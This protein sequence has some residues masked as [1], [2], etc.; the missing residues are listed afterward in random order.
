VRVQKSRHL[1]LL[2]GGQLEGVDVRNLLEIK[3]PT[4]TETD[5]ENSYLSMLC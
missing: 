2:K 4:F 5:M 1:Q 3:P